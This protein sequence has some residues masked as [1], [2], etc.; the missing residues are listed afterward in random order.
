MRAL[1]YTFCAVFLRQLEYYEGILFLTTNRINSFDTA[2]KSRIHLAIKYHALSPAYK[3]DLWKS[4]IQNVA[5]EAVFDW[6]DEEYLAE[7]GKVALN[8]RQIKNTV[9]TAYALAVNARAELSRVHVEMALQAMRMFEK[10][11]DENTSTSGDIR[12]D[13]PVAKRRR[14]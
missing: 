9:R 10:D 8:G 4:F 11:F 12:T 14:L 1:A 13:D 3:M 6:L 2:F 7:L 5:E